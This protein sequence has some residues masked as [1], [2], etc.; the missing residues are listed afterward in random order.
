MRRRVQS[1]LDQDVE[2]VIRPKRRSR[3]AKLWSDV[4]VWCAGGAFHRKRDVHEPPLALNLQRNR[5]ARLEALQQQA[6]SLERCRPLVIEAADDVSRQQRYFGHGPRRARRD[7]DA[8][9]VPER[10]KTKPL[11]LRT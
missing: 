5:R 10:R 6:Q 8:V 11:P 2:I 9:V 1:T 7:D 3:K 4:S